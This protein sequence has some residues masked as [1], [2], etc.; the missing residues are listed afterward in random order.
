MGALPV[1]A[2]D[3]CNGLHA[4]YGTPPVPG[5]TPPPQI[6]KAESVAVKPE[7]AVSAPATSRARPQRNAP[8]PRVRW[9]A[10]GDLQCGVLRRDA[11]SSSV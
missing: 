7:P 10:C 5:T 3:T 9:C 1:P 11:G 4:A 6:V 8:A 2:L